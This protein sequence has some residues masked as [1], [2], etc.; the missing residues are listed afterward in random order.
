ML[1]NPRKVVCQKLHHKRTT[2]GSDLEVMDPNESYV[3]DFIIAEVKRPLLGA[4][5]LCHTG[6][7]V[8]ISSESLSSICLRRCSCAMR[9]NHYSLHA[10]A[11]AEDKF[12]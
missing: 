4:D 5:F 2:D 1:K 6:L 12:G 11:V 8:D 9:T 3:W 7:L 10:I